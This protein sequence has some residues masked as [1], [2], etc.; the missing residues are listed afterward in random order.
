VFF[1]FLASLVFPKVKRVK[2][3]KF[4]FVI[5]CSLELTQLIQTSLLNK[6]KQYFAI[7][8]LIGNSFNW[9]DTPFYAVGGGI[10]FLGL[11]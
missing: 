8:A 1:I 2:L 11:K 4:V 9:M 5:T 3:A 10:G 7:Q 6:L